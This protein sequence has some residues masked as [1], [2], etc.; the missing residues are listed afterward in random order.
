MRGHCGWVF[1]VLLTRLAPLAP[2]IALSANYKTIYLNVH[3]SDKCKKG[4]PHL[5]NI[6]SYYIYINSISILFRKRYKFNATAFLLHIY[7]QM[8]IYVGNFA[9][10]N[11]DRY[12]F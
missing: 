10:V 8:S 6:V 1:L 12:M 7:I 5:T 11:C 3:F 2:L 9:H 4:L